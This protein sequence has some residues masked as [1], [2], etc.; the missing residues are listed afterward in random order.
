MSNRE[1]YK[2]YEFR[3][4]AKIAKLKVAYYKLRKKFIK[5]IT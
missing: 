1:G 3:N 2:K 5:C 4:E